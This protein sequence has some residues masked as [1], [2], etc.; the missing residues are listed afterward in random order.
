MDDL[1]SFIL[2]I[3]A[4][5]I[6]SL[7]TLWFAG[8]LGVNGM[9]GSHSYAGCRGV[10]ADPRGYQPGLH[11]LVDRLLGHRRHKT[12]AGYAHLADWHR[13]ES[14][15]KVGNIIAAVMET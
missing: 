5:V 6:V 3:L 10:E 2:S 7:T 13:V 1:I 4:G 9:D 8:Y 12:T 11:M 15:E 14:A